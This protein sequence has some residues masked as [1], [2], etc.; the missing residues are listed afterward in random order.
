MAKQ[1]RTQVDVDATPERV[2]QV[3]TD[4]AAYPQWNPFIVG[5]RAT[6]APVGG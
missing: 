6:P 2:W 1:L 4:L 5:P 3:L